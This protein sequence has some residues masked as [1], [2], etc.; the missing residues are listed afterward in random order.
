MSLSLFYSY[1]ATCFNKLELHYCMIPFHL[2]CKC[3]IQYANDNTHYFGEWRI[4]S[5]IS[6]LHYSGLIVHYYATCKPSTCTHDFVTNTNWPHNDPRHLASLH[7]NKGG[8]L[9][10]KFD[11]I[12]SSHRRTSQGTAAPQTRA[13]L[14]FFGQ[15]V[16]FRAEASSQ[17]WI[18]FVFIKRKK[19]NSFCLVGQSAWNPGFLLII[20]GWGESVSRAK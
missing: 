8:Q 3:F 6:A 7:R 19:R 17:K 5:R 4:F 2:H 9:S 1:L 16:F 20:T 18:F 13:K 10:D 12:A 11:R 14:L 15:K